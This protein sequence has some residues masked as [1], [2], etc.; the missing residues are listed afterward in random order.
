VDGPLEAHADSF[1]EVLVGRCYAPCSTVAQVQ[2]MAHL[3]R[4]MDEHD[5]G[6]DELSVERVGEF[7]VARQRAGYRHPVSLRSVTPLLDHL[8]SLGATPTA[9]PPPAGPAVD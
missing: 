2:L 8:A 9:P 4:W 5:L 3:S 7:V 6:D 1:I